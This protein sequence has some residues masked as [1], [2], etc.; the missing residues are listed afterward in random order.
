MIQY[1]P[2]NLKYPE[3]A[4]KN[5]ITGKVF[6]EFLVDEKGKVRDAKIKQS[7]NPLLDDEA[8]RVISSMPDWNPGRNDKDKPVKVVMVLPI[9]FKLDDSKGEK[10]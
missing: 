2:A 1:I 8:L 3:E 6:V 5:G 10:K 7:V 4:K 9:M